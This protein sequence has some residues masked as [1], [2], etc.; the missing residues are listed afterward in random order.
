MVQLFIREEFSEE[1]AA[2]LLAVMQRNDVERL[3]AQLTRSKGRVFFHKP[4]PADVLAV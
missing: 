1:S 4:L 2:Q 3:G